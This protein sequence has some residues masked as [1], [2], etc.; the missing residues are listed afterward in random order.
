MRKKWHNLFLLFPSLCTLYR[1]FPLLP[2]SLLSLPPW[3]SLNFCNSVL[4]SSSSEAVLRKQ[5][6]MFVV[7]VQEIADCIVVPQHWHCSWICPVLCKRNTLFTWTNTTSGVKPLTATDGIFLLIST[8]L[9]PLHT[10]LRPTTD[11]PPGSPPPQLSPSLFFLFP[12][13]PLSLFFSPGWQ[14]SSLAKN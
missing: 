14:Q 8:D 6:W 1:L 12:L 5:H 10:Y 13:T 4:G 9:S 7:K 11:N 2:P 3:F